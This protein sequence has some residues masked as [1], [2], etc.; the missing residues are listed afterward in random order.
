MALNISF[1]DNYSLTNEIL[2][3]DNPTDGAVERTAMNNPDMKKLIFCLHGLAL[4]ALPLLVFEFAY[5]L[6]VGTSFSVEFAGTNHAWARPDLGEAH[7]MV[8]QTLQW[9]S[10]LGWLVAFLQIEAIAR[11]LSAGEY[12]SQRVVARFR[13]LSHALLGFAVLETLK[14]P[15]IAVYLVFADALPALPEMSVFDIVRMH[16]FLFTALFFVFTRIAEV[17]LSLKSDADLTI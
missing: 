3:P 8:L 12:F 13:R 7:W 16:T 10:K 11:L 6:V 9:V 4:G 5:R 1:I 14:H 15:A 2:R 17:G